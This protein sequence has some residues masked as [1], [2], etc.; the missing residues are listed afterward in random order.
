M[1][2][3]APVPTAS[4][5]TLTLRFWNP[6]RRRRDGRERPA[7]SPPLP[8]CN[9]RPTYRS[10]IVKHASPEPAAAML[11]YSTGGRRRTVFLRHTLPDG[12]Q[13][14]DWM[15][16]REAKEEAPL[17]SF[18]SDAAPW[19]GGA[20]MPWNAVAT[21]DHRCAYLEYEGPVSGGRGSVV[22]LAS[23]WVEVHT[24]TPGAVCVDLDIVTADGAGW[25][26]QLRGTSAA[27]AAQETS[28]VFQITT[29][30]PTNR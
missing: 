2:T 11:S 13:H 22:R 5:R 10:F 17:R 29:A 8:R 27:V 25:R 18:R 3:N 30:P 12:S 24:D 16:Q 9:G 20:A 7:K 14:I 19:E 26:G 23:G 1:Y 6:G 15:Y 28:W 21:P 4:Y